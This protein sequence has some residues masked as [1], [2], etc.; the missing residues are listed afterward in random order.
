M[1]SGKT[2]FGKALAE[3]LETPFIDLDNYIEEN[4][5][6]TITEI[7]EERGEKGFRLLEREMLEK[8][9][10]DEGNAIVACGGGTPCFKKNIEYLNKNGLTVFLETST[11]VLISRLQE[12]NA[13]RPLMAG[14]SNEEIEDKVLSQLCE[15]LPYYMEAKL[16][17]HGDDLET[18]EQIEENIENFVTSYPSVFR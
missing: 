1:A 2:T 12:E 16:K 17:W 18:P 15:R 4:T 10:N 13:G 6:K 5:S 11:P 8:V 7:F 14:K 9:V 3:K